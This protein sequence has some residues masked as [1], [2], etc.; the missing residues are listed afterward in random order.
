MESRSVHGDEDA[1]QTK[2]KKKK[3][4]K[5]KRI[6]GGRLSVSISPHDTNPRILEESKSETKIK[7]NRETGS[8]PQIVEMTGTYPD[9]SNLQVLYIIVPS[10]EMNILQV[11]PSPLRTPEERNSKALF[12]PPIPIE[13]CPRSAQ[14]SGPSCPLP[15]LE[16]SPSWH[17]K[18]RGTKEKWTRP[19]VTRAQ[20]PGPIGPFNLTGGVGCMSER[21]RWMIPSP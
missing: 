12:F 11:C 3:K 21:S 13:G 14:E 6:Q 1:H 18:C 9:A 19:R 7:S 20:S 2:E 4:K 10:Q 16:Q 15:Q 5:R 8:N 17:R